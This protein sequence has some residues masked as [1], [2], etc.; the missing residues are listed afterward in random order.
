MYGPIIVDATDAAEKEMNITNGM[1]VDA[2]CATKSITTG[3]SKTGPM[4]VRNML[5]KKSA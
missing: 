4:M 3:L 2:L 5:S 1:A